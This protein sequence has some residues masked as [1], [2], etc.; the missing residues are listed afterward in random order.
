M[1]SVTLGLVSQHTIPA[2]FIDSLL[3]L[4]FNTIQKGVQVHFAISHASFIDWA[5]NICVE[6]A[7]KQKTDYL[8]FLD[9]DVLVPQDI[10]LQL[11][12]HEKDVVSG[13]YNHKN[14]PFKPQAYLENSNGSFTPQLFDEPKL[15]E[16]DAAGSGCLLVKT[17]IFEK[18]EKPWFAVILPNTL[19]EY[20]QNL[21]IDKENGLGE[22]MFFCKKLKKSGFKIFYDNSIEG[23]QHI[24]AKAGNEL[25][26]KYLDEHKGNKNG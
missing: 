16:V 13:P 4:V 5:R 12:K 9:A 1:V 26:Y 20:A 8:F 2:E 10:I 24:G 7:L 6:K 18:I 15:Y 14:P 17:S 11:L 25:F 21:G 23:V 22:D 19:P 3:P